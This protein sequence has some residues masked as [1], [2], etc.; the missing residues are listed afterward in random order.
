MAQWNAVDEN[1]PNI[2]VWRVSC[3][4]SMGDPAALRADASVPGRHLGLVRLALPADRPELRVG[5]PVGPR[6][7]SRSCVPELPGIA[8]SWRLVFGGIAALGLVAG[9]VASLPSATTV[10]QTTT[11]VRAMQL[12]TPTSGWALTSQRLT[13]TDDGGQTWRSITPPGLATN[14]VLAVHFL[15][16][17][18]G[19]IVRR[20]AQETVEPG[21]TELFVHRT[22]DGGSTWQQSSAASTAYGA[23][24]RATLHFGDQLHGLIVLSLEGSSALGA[25]Q[26]LASLDGGVTWTSRPSPGRGEPY[27][28][29]ATDVWVT[30]GRGGAFQVFRSRDNG[31]TWSAVPIPANAGRGRA[32]FSAPRSFGDFA[33]LPVAWDD[34][35]GGAVGVYISSDGG[36]TWRLAFEHATPERVTA[37]VPVPTA[38]LDSSTW[39]LMSPSAERIVRVSDE[40]R[41]SQVIRPRGLP[42]GVLRISF[43][44]ETHGWAL[45]VTTGPGQ[46]FATA[47]GG[48]SWK[49]LRP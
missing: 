2:S 41:G 7:A 6:V 34:P 44:D 1:D 37:G 26:I 22:T 3:V 21:R 48:R 36:A 14:S 12:L 25:A 45:H 5:A 13:W 8:M 16:S 27:V 10:A 20:G 43:P 46:L 38:V 23:P 40:G 32:V 11:D 47:D 28:R 31:L 24:G 42:K 4:P 15:D 18:R 35:S 19:W 30:G 39:L 17:E 29:G 9:L 49:E 33:V